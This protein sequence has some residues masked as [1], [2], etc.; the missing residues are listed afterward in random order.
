MDGSNTN[1]ARSLG[2][3]LLRRAVRPSIRALACFW[4]LAVVAA[5]LELVPAQ[6]VRILVDEVIP[7]ADEQALARTLSLLIGLFICHAGLRVTRAWLGAAVGARV[8]NSLRHEVLEVILDRTRVRTRER[9]ASDLLARL[10]N[11]LAEVRN[12]IGS[13]GSGVLANAFLIIGAAALMLKHDPGLALILLA[14]APIFLLANFVTAPYL[15]RRFRSLQAVRAA[16]K[17]A[18]HH[19][20]RGADAARLLGASD[21]LLRRFDATAEDMTRSVTRTRASA[22]AIASTMLFVADTMML[23]AWYAGAHSVW[24]GQL[25]LG[26]LLMYIGYLTLFFGPLRSISGLQESFVQGWAAIQ[27]I[28][29]VLG[30]L[31]TSDTE[32]RPRS[33]S[34]APAI[35]LGDVCFG[36]DASR[37]PL[38]E[39]LSLR[40]QAGECVV[41][42]GPSG[43]GKSTLLRLI[44]GQLRPQRGRVELDGHD[45]TRM[46]A[47]QLGELLTI[48][49][50]PPL[51]LTGTLSE[52]ITLISEDDDA[53]AVLQ[54]S[55]SACAHEFVRA[56]PFCYDELLRDEGRRLSHGERQRLAL[57][58]VFFNPKPVILLDEITTGLDR[59][60]ALRILA[61]LSTLLVGRTAL[62]ISHGDDACLLA[63]RV[64]GI[65]GTT[66]PGALTG[67]LAI[68]GLAA[69]RVTS[70]SARL[71][72][73]TSLASHAGQLHVEIDGD[74]AQAS[75]RSMF[76]LSA[77]HRGVE[78]SD[79]STG[80]VL[81]FLPSLAELEPSVAELLR[82]QLCASAHNVM[83][84]AR[85]V[86]RR[87]LRVEL[88]VT[89]PASVER[90]II[91]DVHEGIRRYPRGGL[92]IRCSDG[93]SF[94]TP[95]DGRAQRQMIRSL[96]QFV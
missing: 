55:V 14:P 84:D 88:E 52:N 70:P 90:V 42:R 17:G 71:L 13:G 95:T 22:T 94:A 91:D 66:E 23:V 65:D 58:R 43:V 24:A 37:V 85:M 59:A 46:N 12:V 1:T 45:V 54:A 39:G 15:H 80:R 68:E 73:P 56:L 20:V 26:E 48:I 53:M 34:S 38:F 60:T 18:L 93:R 29:A 69:S 3:A 41:L 25:S 8:V 36:F 78:L 9:S 57:T 31:S 11:D 51:I 72:A 92:I 64:I 30:D 16:N 40:V 50:Q 6:I 7:T 79:A 81:G 35:V 63:N 32:R 62:V 75:A 89:T 19:A 67:P 21:F 86:G 47:E 87:G 77:P 10:E 27:R 83:V 5:S 2:L 44:S 4:G 74:S 49:Q 28:G 76:P 61:N 96:D 82:A 33:S